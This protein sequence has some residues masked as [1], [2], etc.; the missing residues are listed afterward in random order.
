ME[1]TACFTG[2]RPRSD[3]RYEFRELKT[4][5]LAARVDD[6][7]RLLCRDRDVKTFLC[8]MAAGFDL[9]AA[10]R[11]LALRRQ[12]EI[13]ED[14]ALIAV[15]P[16]PEH[17]LDMPSPLWE[18]L[19]REVL[20]NA[21]DQCVIF[22]EKSRAAFQRRNQFLVDHASYVL[23]YW[24]HNPRTGTGQTVRMASERERVLINLFD[25]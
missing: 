15:L 12:S 17:G 5:Q 21:Q 23:A 18:Q 6:A 2:H 7:I 4:R 10:G 1:S 13:P 25:L 16:Y 11:L 24:N 20:F 3:L 8:G 9:F 19:H 22:T 14:T